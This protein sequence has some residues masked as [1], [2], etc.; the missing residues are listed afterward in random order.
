MFGKRAR[1]DLGGV[2]AEPDLLAAAEQAEFEAS[3]KAARA[4]AE[5]RCAPARSAPLSPP[6]EAADEEIEWT[7]Q[8]DV[9]RPRPVDANSYL[10]SL[11]LP[12]PIEAKAGQAVA[13]VRRAA[14]QH[15]NEHLRTDMAVELGGLLC[16]EALYDRA[17]DLFIVV[18]EMAVPAVNGD[19]T[20]TT[21]SYTPAAWEAISPTLRQMNSEWTIVGS[22]H[23]H[24]GLG[25]FMSPT[26]LDTQAEVF[27]H[28]W[29]AAMVVDPS[30]NT[31]GLFLG[32]SGK[33]CRFHLV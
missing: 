24:P 23:S 22:Y 9:Y 28:D 32:S 30:A 5:A 8:E 26:D 31:C 33:P 3:V 6:G 25:V 21:F 13:L 14:Y 1:Q 27:P 2:N 11:G 7:E 10:R 20:P 16:G 29:Q 18:I 15:L 19:G 4:R 17:L 12:K